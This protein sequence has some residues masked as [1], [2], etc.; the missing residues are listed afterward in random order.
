MMINYIYIDIDTRLLLYKTCVVFGGT[1][2]SLL[3]P[4]VD[5]DRTITI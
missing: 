2:Q 5:S 3:V 4:L 1:A